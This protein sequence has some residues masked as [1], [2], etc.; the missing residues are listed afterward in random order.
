MMYPYKKEEGNIMKTSKYFIGCLCVM[1]LTGCTNTEDMEETSVTVLDFGE[2]QLEGYDDTDRYTA[3]KTENDDEVMIKVKDNKADLFIDVF[4]YRKEDHILFHERTKDTNLTTV[5][6]HTNVTFTDNHEIKGCK[7]T[8]ASI[9][10]ETVKW[11]DEQDPISSE[12]SQEGELPST[13]CTSNSYGI[14][15]T[16][17]NSLISKNEDLPVSKQ[18]EKQGNDAITYNYEDG[19]TYKLI[20]DK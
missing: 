2:V 13:T 15:M 12:Y 18:W 9:E 17:S 16:N 14:L 11:T 3:Y 5:T 10:T 20:I 4:T 8:T 19:F 1:L 6:I 7:P